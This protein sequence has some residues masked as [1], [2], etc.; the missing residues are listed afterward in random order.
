MQQRQA[1]QQLQ[2]Q[3]QASDAQQPVQELAAILCLVVQHTQHNALQEVPTFCRVVCA[4][5][6][7]RSALLAAATGRLC[8]ARHGEDMWPALPWLKQHLQLLRKLAFRVSGTHLGRC[9]RQAFD[10]LCATLTEAAR[11]GGLCLAELTAPWGEWAAALGAGW[12]GLM[13]AA[14]SYSNEQNADALCFGC[15]ACASTHPQPC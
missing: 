7:L 2:H 5:P 6:Q 1:E 3:Q 15:S 8:L 12:L 14:A 9:E 11:P 10:D 13:Q 4:H